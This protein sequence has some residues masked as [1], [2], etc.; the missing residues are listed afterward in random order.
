M[1]P[2]NWL[3]IWFVAVDQTA[4]GRNGAYIVNTKLVFGPSN[5]FSERV[6]FL[7]DTTFVVLRQG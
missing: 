6:N 7:H 1:F 2:G 3:C 5:L 4:L